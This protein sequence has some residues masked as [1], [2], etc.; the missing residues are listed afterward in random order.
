[1]TIHARSSSRPPF[2]DGKARIIH[3]T[4]GHRMVVDVSG[5]ID[6]LTAPAFRDAI[7]G[8]LDTGALELWIDLTEF[9]HSSGV[10]ALLDAHARVRELR[11]RLTIICP[12]GCVRRLFEVA[13]VSEVLPLALDRAPAHR[14]S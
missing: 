5:E 10:H 3:R 12:P 2:P 9:M 8:A 4:V 13:G 1:M 7:A 6:M 11:R 14:D